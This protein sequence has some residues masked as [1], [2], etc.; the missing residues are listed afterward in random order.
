M[1]SIDVTTRK[2]DVRPETDARRLE[3]ASQAESLAREERRYAQKA[4]RSQSGEMA[5][6]G[7]LD[8]DRGRFGYMQYIHGVLGCVLAVLALIHIP[9]P[10]PFAWL[11][12]ALASSLAFITLKPELSMGFSRILAIAT[13]GMMFFFFALF[14][15]VAPTLE[16]D[17]YRTQYGWAAVCL[18]LSAFVMIP[19]LSEYSCRLKAD[20][21]E[22]R[23]ARR[24]AFF[25]VPAHIRP[26][27]R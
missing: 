17:W 5:Q 25:S 1:H 27:S 7:D 4:Q 16:A 11:P 14:F 22:A 9:F 21:M 24:T 12:F 10:E 26:E 18:I 20:C 13:A 2:V 15:L 3:D 8:I 19:I 23:A 6:P